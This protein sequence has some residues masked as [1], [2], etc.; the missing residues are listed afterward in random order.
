M[1]VHWVQV[2]TYKLKSMSKAQPFF[3]HKD[4]KS[5]D[6]SIVSIQHEHGKGRQLS[7]AVPAI[8]AVYHHRRLSW[9][10]FVSDPKS[11]CKNKLQ[12]FFFH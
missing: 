3:F 10:Y 12:I 2:F 9:L 7:C 8:T 4:F 5:S 1:Q 6:S 11:P